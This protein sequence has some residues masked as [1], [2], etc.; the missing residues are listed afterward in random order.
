MLNAE[1]KDRPGSFLRALYPRITPKA[2]KRS[3]SAGSGCTNLVAPVK[4]WWVKGQSGNPSGRAKVH[5]DLRDI[6]RVHTQAA[7]DV[8]VASLSDESGSVRLN[9]ANSL[10]DRGWGRPLPAIP[11]TPGMGTPY[12]EVRFVWPADAQTV[13]AHTNG[14][15]SFAVSFD[16]EADPTDPMGD[17]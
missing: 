2:E 4:N 11:D 8:L 13:T 15:G 6:A 10:L 14:N 1:C 12:L 9:A 5:V 3:R 16:P 7:I 17:P